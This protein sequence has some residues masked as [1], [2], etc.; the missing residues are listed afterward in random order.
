M[1]AV[2]FGTR[3][4]I[5]ALE[6]AGHTC[7]EIVVAGGATRSDLWL[8][9]HAD[10][11]GK[12]VVVCENAD[13]PLLGCAILASVSSG[14]HGSVEDAVKSMVR[15]AKTL[16]PSNKESQQYDDIYRGVYNQIGNAVRP[17]A[18]S[19]GK[20]RGGHNDETMPQAEEES[21]Q[22]NNAATLRHTTISPSLL[23]ADWSDMRGE[24]MRCVEL[25]MTRLHV[26]VFDGVFLDS[27][28][29]LTFGPQMVAAIRKCSSATFLDLHMCVERP[30]RY[31]IPMK[32]AGADSFIFQWEAMADVVEA[33]QLAQ[34]VIDSGMQCG[35]S[36]NPSTSIRDIFPLLKTGLVSIVDVLAV[37]PGFG[38][39][40][41][42]EV[43]IDKVEGLKLYRHSEALDFDIMVDGGINDTTAEKIRAEILVAGTFLLQHPESMRTGFNALRMASAGAGKHQQQHGG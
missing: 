11:T 33:I 30:A 1:E 22:H 23:A 19:I 28:Y 37:E 15:T 9:M 5:D 32:K 14:V 40:E 43:V 25:G 13:A 35:V 29:A 31:V 36:I 41:F 21:R 3:A 34:E 7:K 8:Q 24:V 16:T 17:I 20:I 10:V 39:Q 2:C 26:D 27:P 4:C 6:S 12:S 18:H 42:Q 38:G